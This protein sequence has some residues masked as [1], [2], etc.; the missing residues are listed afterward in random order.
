MEDTEYAIA[1]AAINE[2]ANDEDVDALYELKEK[3][4]VALQELGQ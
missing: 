3:I 1:L 2:L 4:E